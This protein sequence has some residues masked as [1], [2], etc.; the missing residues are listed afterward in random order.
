ML[1]RRGVARPARLLRAAALFLHC[2]LQY[3]LVFRPYM[4]EKNVPHVLHFA[5]MNE[6]F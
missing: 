3:I 1:E 5:I 4:R 6:L 2:I